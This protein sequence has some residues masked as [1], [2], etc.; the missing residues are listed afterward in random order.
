MIRRLFSIRM[1]KL[2]E[3]PRMR[4]QGHRGFGG[5]VVENTLPAFQAAIESKL[6]SIETD[7]FLTKDDVMIVCHGDTDFGLA[8]LRP[9]DSPCDAPY[10][11]MSIGGLTYEQLSKYGYYASGGQRIPTVTELCLLFKGTN[12]IMNMEIKELD[13]KIGSMII[14]EFRRHGMLPQLFLS[15]FYHYHRRFITGY[16]RSQGLTDIPFGFLTY[17]VYEGFT[18]PMMKEMKQGDFL[19]VSFAALVRYIAVYPQLKEAT[20]SL[21]MGVNIWF[22]G[23]MSAEIEVYE[24]FR[25]LHNLGINTL[26]TNCPT[27]AVQ[28]NEV[29]ELEKAQAR[30]TGT[31]GPTQHVPAAN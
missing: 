29:I 17:S 28:F 18:E 1:E 16:T 15:S 30:A 25:M 2:T 31:S 26:I 21:G 20:D 22:D 11:E 19:T 23:V 10:T 7:V 9:L 8:K 27:K 12:K 5:E 3:R 6:D 13:T 14:D 4:L 24:N